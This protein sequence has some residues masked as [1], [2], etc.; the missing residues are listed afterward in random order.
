MDVNNSEKVLEWNSEFTCV[1]EGSD[2]AIYLATA[3]GDV[4][5]LKDGQLKQEFHHDGRPSGIA[6][7]EIKRVVYIADMMNQIVYSKS[8]EE[9][10]PP[11]EPNRVVDQHEGVSLLGPNSLVFAEN[12]SYNNKRRSNPRQIGSSSLTV[13]HLERLL[14]RIQREVCL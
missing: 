2:G 13:V 11:G 5:R 9:G 1:T 10:T 7:D 8:I 12:S 6:I 4:L 3:S 14:S